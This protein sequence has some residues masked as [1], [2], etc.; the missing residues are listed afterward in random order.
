[1]EHSLFLR[2]YKFEILHPT[3][4]ADAEQKPALIAYFDFESGGFQL[5]ADYCYID[6]NNRVKNSRSKNKSNRLLIDAKMQPE[7]P[8]GPNDNLDNELLLCLKGSFY[9]GRRLHR[10]SGILRLNRNLQKKLAPWMIYCNLVDN[11]L[12]FFEIK[13]CLPVFTNLVQTPGNN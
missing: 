6:A 4:S 1:M 8:A 12:D 5:E 3:A 13:F 7:I 11:D 2:Q 10:C 9:N